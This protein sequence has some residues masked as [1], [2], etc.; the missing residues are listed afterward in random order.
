MLFSSTI[1]VTTTSFM[2]KG[3]SLLATFRDSSF[4]TENVLKVLG[5]RIRSDEVI[6]KPIKPNSYKVGYQIITK[7]KVECLTTPCLDSLI[8]K[9]FWGVAV[10]DLC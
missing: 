7:H 10:V 3:D 4:E 1:T 5:W 9:G 8:S 2:I 6:A